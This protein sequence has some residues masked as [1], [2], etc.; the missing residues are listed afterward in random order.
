VFEVARRVS[1]NEARGVRDADVQA[2][3]EHLDEN[4]AIN[5]VAGGQMSFGPQGE[6]ST[7]QRSTHIRVV[8]GTIT[9]SDSMVVEIQLTADG[10]GSVEIVEGVPELVKQA[11]RQSNKEV[12]ALIDAMFAD[13]PVRGRDNTVTVRGKLNPRQVNRFFE[14]YRGP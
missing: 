14:L 11:A 12:G 10:P 8:R 2:A 5:V 3:L 1:R 13:K 7:L 4:A 9:F 6:V